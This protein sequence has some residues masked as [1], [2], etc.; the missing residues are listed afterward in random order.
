MI[1]LCSFG[2]AIGSL[3]G[4]IFSIFYVRFDA[5]WKRYLS[6]ILPLGT[7]GG[8]FWGL[9]SAL[10]VSEL[11]LVIT[12]VTWY[13]LAF[14]FS[15]VCFLFI[16]CKIMKDK[17]NKEVL[18]IR[19]IILG[20]KNY[21]DTYYKMRQQEIDDKLNYNVLKQREGELCRKEQLY[22][23]NLSVFKK[24]KEDFEKL[25]QDKLKIKLP[26]NKKL[27]V[28]NELLDLFPSYVEDLGAFVQAI[29]AETD[30]FISE[31]ETIN[32]KDFSA[33]L[34]MLS[35]HIAEHFFN[36]NSKEV[37]VHFRYYDEN[38]NGF[39]KLVCMT[40]GR[41]YKQKLTFIPFDK[42]NMINKSF[43][44]KRALIKSNNVKYDYVSNNST[45]WTDYMT[46]TFYNI[47]KDNKPCLSFGI[48][49]RNSTRFRN[50]LNFL[51]YCKFEIYLQEVI[52]R[53]NLHCSIET[54][55]YGDHNM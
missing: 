7:S 29:N 4:V 30:I 33:Y 32:R 8:G 12:L 25:A 45:I 3:F 13:C 17:D 49:V 5:E 21:I 38:K 1:S 15:F 50:L 37:R 27:L 55:L 41:E 52:E 46:G 2:I 16:M 47:K 20:Q 44:C 9:L 51:N 6:L 48:S 42:A 22:E 54:I 31:H 23:A 36:K 43:E 26:E 19:D 14:L 53:V 39:E 35:V 24:D 11:N 40:A 18:R 34:L 10:G 28:T